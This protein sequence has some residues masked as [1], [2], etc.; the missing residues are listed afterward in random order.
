[1]GVAFRLSSQCLGSSFPTWVSLQAPGLD[2]LLLVQQEMRAPLRAVTQTMVGCQESMGLENAT[3][4][5]RTTT[6]VE[7]TST[8]GWTGLTLW[9]AV[10]F[11]EATWLSHRV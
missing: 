6:N 11:S 7:G 4:L 2:Q 10:T 1:M 8:M 5:S 3:C 9:P